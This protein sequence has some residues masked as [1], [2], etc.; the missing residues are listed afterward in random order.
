MITRHNE[1]VQDNDI[2]LMVGDLSAGLRE[3]QD[4]F[5]EILKSL[6]G[7][8]ILVRGNHDYEPDSFYYSAGFIDVVPFIDAGEYFVSHHP[9]YES[10]WTTPK[11]KETMKFLDRSKHK[12]IIHGHIHNK[13]PNLW[14][15]DGICR[16]NM[17]VDYVPNNYY[18]QEITFPEIIEHLKKYN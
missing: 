3:R 17:S 18:P 16:H 13:D 11:E 5:R 1:I 2:V 12:V 4:L 9:C 14:E 15:S 8:K 6:K 10:K 7:R